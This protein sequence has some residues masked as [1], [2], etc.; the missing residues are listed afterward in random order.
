MTKVYIVSSG[1][2]LGEDVKKLML[3]MQESG[4]EVDIMKATEEQ[5]FKLLDIAEAIPQ[6]TL[7]L[8]ETPPPKPYS[9]QPKTKPINRTYDKRSSIK[10][11]KHR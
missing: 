1:E 2:E 9:T 5:V 7:S 11:Y 4:L 3:E 8:I 6:T 10:H